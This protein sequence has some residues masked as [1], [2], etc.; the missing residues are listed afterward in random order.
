MRVWGHSLVPTQLPVEAIRNEWP[1][2]SSLE[3]AEL[4][5]QLNAGKGLRYQERL[6]TRVHE[7]WARS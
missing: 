4:A 5:K 7:E 6:S 3:L 1:G 2:T